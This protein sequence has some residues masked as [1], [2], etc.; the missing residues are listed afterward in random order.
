MKKK[1]QSI[2]PDFV[3]VL[4]ALKRA[5]QDALKLGIQTRTPVYVMKNGKIVNINPNA[6]KGVA[7]PPRPKKKK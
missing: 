2:D 4:P 7:P 5:A 3:G 6:R 1:M